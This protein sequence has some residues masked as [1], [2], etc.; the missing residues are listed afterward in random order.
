[1]KLYNKIS[2]CILILNNQ[3]TDKIVRAKIF[4]LF[5]IIGHINNVKIKN[6]T[7]YC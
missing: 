1:M 5:N 3:R 2:Y 7:S 4:I 6:Y